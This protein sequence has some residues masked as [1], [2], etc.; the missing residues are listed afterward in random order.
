MLQYCFTHHLCSRNRTVP[1]LQPCWPN[2]NSWL[3]QP[4][5]LSCLSSGRATLQVV[6]ACRSTFP[7]SRN[8]VELWI[9]QST[10][11]A[12]HTVVFAGVCCCFVSSRGKCFFT[13]PDPQ[14]FFVASLF[15][16][17]LRAYRAGDS[18]FCFCKAWCSPVALTPQCKEP[19]R[20]FKADAKFYCVR[21]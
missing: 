6:L 21:R 4:C 20:L 7:P 8:L 14:A 13:W 19:I 1:P 9:H 2:S 11:S 15:S 12:V 16:T 3:V 10:G 5:L 17:D 18:L